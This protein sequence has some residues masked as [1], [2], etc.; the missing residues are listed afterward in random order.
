MMRTFA[1]IHEENATRRLF[2]RF[3][4]ALANGNLEAILG[5]M[6][7]QV[8][9]ETNVDGELVPYAAAVV[10]EDAMRRKLQLFLETFEIGAY[11]TDRLTVTGKI[12][13][14]R[15]KAIFVHRATGERLMIN[16]RLSVEVCDGAIVSVTVFHDAKY[17]EAFEQFVNWLVMEERGWSD[18]LV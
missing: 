12:A 17:L 14:S 11:V 9:Q 2:E 1:A 13:R 7:E 8:T 4:T 10:G 18:R 6:S 15:M 3:A 5:C 16:F